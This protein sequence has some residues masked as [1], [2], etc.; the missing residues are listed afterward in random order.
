MRYLV[1]TPQYLSA[2]T[3]LAE[4]QNSVLPES[5]KKALRDFNGDINKNNDMMLKLLDEYLHNDER[6]FTDHYLVGSPFN[7]VINNDFVGRMIN[8]KPSADRVLDA[9]A[10]VWKS[11]NSYISFKATPSNSNA[12]IQASKNVAGNVPHAD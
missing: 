3:K 12:A 6:Y 7:N 9:I 8:L 5:I 11:T 4:F 10:T 2:V 1:V